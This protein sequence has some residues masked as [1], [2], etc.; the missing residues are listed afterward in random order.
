MTIPL[1]PASSF[2]YEDGG[3]RALPEEPLE[4]TLASRPAID[5]TPPEERTTLFQIVPE[6]SRRT[7]V[8][9]QLVIFAALCIIAVVMVAWFG[10]RGWGVR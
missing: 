4:V 8:D 5:P 3:R 2:R 1:P 7:V 6:R 10:A 9:V